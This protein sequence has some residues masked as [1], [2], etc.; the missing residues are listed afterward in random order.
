MLEFLRGRASDRK[1]RLF[2]VACC[3]RVSGAIVCEESRRAVDAAE[4]YSDGSVPAGDLQ[5]CFLL[6]SLPPS[7]YGQRRDRS[8]ATFAACNAA[9]KQADAAAYFAAKAVG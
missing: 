3:R 5:A 9:H 2:A 1:L 7:S 6:A 8:L 4:R